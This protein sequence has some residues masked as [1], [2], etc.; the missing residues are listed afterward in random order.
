MSRTHFRTLELPRDSSHDIHSVSST[1]ANTDGTQATA[2]GSVGV[3][4]NQHHSRISIILQDDLSKERDNHSQ[5]RIFPIGLK[6]SSDCY[7]KWTFSGFLEAQ[8]KRLY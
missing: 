4:T 8:H 7:L 5:S 1:H 2:I 6:M 3:G